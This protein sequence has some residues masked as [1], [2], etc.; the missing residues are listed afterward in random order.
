MN[1]P[2]LPGGMPPLREG[3]GGCPSELRLSRFL[4]RELDSAGLEQLHQH[5]NGCAE[6]AQR[7]WTLQQA[8]ASF[9][10]RFKTDSLVQDLQRRLAHAD[11]EAIL[12]ELN[13]QPTPESEPLESDAGLQDVSPRPKTV[14]PGVLESLWQVLVSTVKSGLEGL[15]ALLRGP[16]LSRGLALGVLL[17]ISLVGIR[18]GL[19]V[20][21]A[22]GEP[23]YRGEKSGIRAPGPLEVYVL[24]RGD[25]L[26]ARSGDAFY[27][28]DRLQF[29]VRPGSYRHLFLVSLDAD[30]QLHPFVPDDDGSSLTLNGDGEQLLPHAIQLDDYRGLERIFAVYSD[31]PFTFERL[32]QAV[33]HL[34]SQRP[35]PLATLEQLPLAGMA[36]VS[37]LMVKP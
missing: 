3:P 31:Q 28:G 32:E 16:Q 15:V 5:L 18:Q 24:R 1:Q 21:D 37:F 33:S 19:R 27:A 12:S 9:K 23:P 13:A 36:Q 29:M 11:R 22:T 34:P 6:C 30:G 4:S 8:Q 14:P 20:L 7:V 25:V 10:A 2:L 26:P 35:L 17:L